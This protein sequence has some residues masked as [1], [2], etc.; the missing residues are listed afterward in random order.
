MSMSDQLAAIILGLVQ[1]LTEFLPVSSTAHLI[2]VSDALKLD[3]EKF[4]LSFDVALHM[5]TAL[6]V[7]L[8]FAGTWIGLIADVARGRWR[9]PLVVV[10]GTIP[11]AIAGV[12]LETAVSTTLRSVVFIAIG[13]LVGSAIF[14]L[15]ERIG[16]RARKL[17]QVTLTDALVVGVAQAIA[18]VPGISRSG[19]T[20]SA[21]LFR[22]LER[23][24]ATRFAFLLSTP[25]ILGAGVKTLLDA[26]KL[27]G[28]TAQ[29]DIVAIG[30]AVSFLS[31][32]AA[33]AFMVR[34]LRTHS[35]NVF[36]IYRVA[37]AAVILVA[38]ALG[39]LG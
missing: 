17:D 2:I 30:F 12:L 7:L 15:A 16:V 39:G 31:G 22:G 19:I 20:I 27:S 3:P 37:L 11:A 14:V 26:R 35:L 29:L 38:Y 33:V 36:A 18:L 21:G 32:L 25:V 1:G 23:G 5:G 10:V 28:L 6:A 8:Y 34:Y 9:L 13:L 4:G 24:D